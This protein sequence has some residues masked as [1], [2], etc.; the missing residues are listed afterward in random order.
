MLEPYERKLSCTVLR[1]EGG[2]NA[3]DLLDRPADLSQREGRIE[4]QGNQN[5][6]VDIFR[7]VTDATFD[8]YLF[9][10]VQK[11]QEFISQIMTSKSPVRTCD[12]MDE[13]ALSYAEIKALCAGNPL[14]AEK[15]GLDVEVAKLKMLKAHHQSQLYHLEDKLRLH[16]P[17]QIE[18]TKANIEGY[19]ADIERLEINTVHVA[20][21]TS[22]MTIGNNSF[23][24]RKDSGAALIE[25]CRSIEGIG[26]GKVGSY[27][28][29]EMSVSFDTFNKKYK[30]H[31]KGAI[32]HTVSL[33][34]DPAGNIIRI[35][36]AFEKL[37]TFLNNA[38]EKLETLYS[39]IENAKVELIKPF[40]K[41]VDLS[42]KS[43][44]LTELDSLLS[45]DG[46]DE[47]TSDSL[48]GNTPDADG[49]IPVNSTTEKVLQG[50]QTI[51]PALKENF[52]T[53][54]TK[55]EVNTDN[56]MQ[57]KVKNKSHDE[58]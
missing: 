27:R 11:K 36:N 52:T 24:E 53:A 4:R 5:P 25:A 30:C 54:V 23:I 39:Q 46:K 33:G 20:E 7:Y 34:S 9:Q 2:S 16:F 26:A 42:E 37:P 50:S 6:E 38:E 35:D 22:P 44:R 45:L 1:G 41:E 55:A 17:K 56:P 18:G 32:T 12:D 57:D 43:A 3:A 47:T 51:T 19:K 21:G 8:S 49:N 15:M 31:L 13:Q 10:T 28:G 40:P 58:R 48:D 14:I 29:F